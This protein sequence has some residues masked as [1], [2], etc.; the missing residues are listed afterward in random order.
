M[1]AG[2]SDKY[3]YFNQHIYG[4][5]QG[6]GNMEPYEIDDRYPEYAEPY[7]P[8]RGRKKRK[9]LKLNSPLLAVAGAVL[10]LATLFQHPVSVP[11][12]PVIPPQA[13][14]TPKPQPKPEP[15]PVKEPEPAPEPEPVIVIPPDE[16][17]IPPFIPYIP[18]TEPVI[19]P[20][21]PE[22]PPK[23]PDN[24]PDEPDIPPD[25]PDPPVPV[26]DP[27]TVEVDPV[28]EGPDE[29]GRDYPTLYFDMTLVDLKG[30]K[31]T[32]RMFA[33][34]GS[35]FTEIPYP[36]GFDAPVYDPDI[37]TGDVWSDYMICFIDPP[38]G[39][40]IAGKA[41]IVFD[42]TYP[43]GTTGTVESETRPVHNGTYAKID[44]TY[45]DDGR[46]DGVSTNP[47][48][49]ET[50]YTMTF[51]V[52]I[53]DTLVKADEVTDDGDELWHMDS[54]NI[55]HADSI[56]RHT[57]PDGTYHMTYTYVSDTPFPDGEYDFSPRPLFLEDDYNY[58]TPFN[59]YYY[60][61]KDGSG[62]LHSPLFTD[63][64]QE[65]NYSDTNDDFVY[66]FS[67]DLKDA[68]TF[69]P[70]TVTLMRERTN[71]GP[72]DEV[73]GTTLTYSGS[74]TTWTGEITYDMDAVDLDGSRGLLNRMRF[75]CEYYLT[76]GMHGWIF[77]DGTANLWSYKGDYVTAQSAK[78]EDGIVT[79]EFKVDS[80]IVRNYSESALKI[81]ELTLN[82]GGSSWDIRGKAELSELDYFNDTLTVTYKLNGETLGT[83]ADV[84][85]RMLY[86]DENGKIEWRSGDSAAF[87]T[88]LTE[89]DVSLDHVWYWGEFNAPMG[90]QRI[91]V[92]YTVTAND[93]QDIVSDV[94]L[95]S[96]LEPENGISKNGISGS[97]ALAANMDTGGVIFFNSADT[98]VPK[99]VLHYSLGGV[100]QEKTFTFT[101]QKP[102]RPFTPQID[103]TVENQTATLRIGKDSDDRYEY[104]ITLLKAGIEWAKK[105][106]SN[107]TVLSESELWNS[108]ETD[109]PAQ[110][111]GPY[112]DAVGIYYILNYESIDIGELRP[113][114]ADCMMIA[115]SAEGT[116]T[117]PDDGT[118]YELL[119]GVMSWSEFFDLD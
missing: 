61:I 68:D 7:E 28:V 10:L 77:S 106:G 89:P 94:S 55:Y 116:G 86:S 65:H 38:P 18:P 63:V 27:P 59:L 75:E 40:G 24:P 9:A 69:R 105:E 114:E 93:A 107:Y 104:D 99:I 31:A 87:S 80:E 17:Y 32:A 100:A 25:T 2:L 54:W 73:T 72:W 46:K 45:D 101:G 16:P 53:D 111:S 117:D 91:E 23:E 42:I 62:T 41:K 15:Q 4:T 82:S 112:S 36:D 43:D 85:L 90:L 35:G 30:G 44:E 21:E 118:S 76:N 95:T 64:S 110:L 33:D 67:I 92:A 88:V 51:D 71:V 50:Q 1:H 19:P 49:G 6:N 13:S 20:F 58:W 97:G 83:D 47:E 78:L 52:I 103:I 3:N 26:P 102:D 74:G 5:V 115:V 109:N 29:E 22:I 8:V 12:M 37:E 96:E 119:G 79:A 98:W 56:E 39:G 60:F 11:L 14:V 48:T 84:S 34:T 113:A 81:E 70:I 108:S 66:H 57:D